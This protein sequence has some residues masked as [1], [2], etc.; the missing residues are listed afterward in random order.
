MGTTTVKIVILIVIAVLLVAILGLTALAA[1]SWRTVPFLGVVEDR[2]AP[3][4]SSPNCV[5]SD[6]RDELHGYRLW[7]LTA[8]EAWEMIMA[9]VASQPEAR[10][11]EQ[12][13]EYM[14]AEITSPVFG[15]V[16]DLELN[17]RGDK[18]AVRS[19]SRVGYSDLGANRK[20]LEQLASLLKSVE[21][22][23]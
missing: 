23:Y 21:L 19:A 11:V 13:A 14:R 8:P 10:I 4:P 9:V 5:S 16:D 15:F 3:C 6:E 7:T 17:L 18:L 12:T 20:R 1:Q 22:I 2:F